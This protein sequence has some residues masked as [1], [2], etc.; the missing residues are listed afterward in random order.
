L[1]KESALNSFDRKLS[2]KRI[3]EGWELLEIKTVK[4]YKINDILSK[5]L[6][7]NQQIDFINID[8]EG[9]DLSILKSLDWETYS[10]KFLLFESLEMV[11]SG[12]M[13]YNETEEYKFFRSKGYDIIGRTRRTLIFKKV[14][15]NK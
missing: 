11:D 1:F 10:P 6:P 4:T 7:K 5:Y 3:K 15:K 14:E 9:S 2:E 8:V 13:D 12:I